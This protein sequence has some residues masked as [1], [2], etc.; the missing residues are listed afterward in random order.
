MNDKSIKVKSTSWQQ[1]LFIASNQLLN[2]VKDVVLGIGIF[3]IPLINSKI[4]NIQPINSANN[5]FDITKNILQ[6]QN[7]QVLKDISASL[8]LSCIPYSL[9]A[10]SLLRPITLNK[11]ANDCKDLMITDNGTRKGKT[12]IPIRNKISFKNPGVKELI[13]YSNGV[14][15]CDFTA[16]DKL[17][18]LSKK[19]KRYVIDVEDYKT[20]KLKIY[21]KKYAS[22]KMLF[23]KNEYL[24]RKDFELILG[25]NERGQ[26]EK[27]NF[28]KI[29]HMIIS[30]SS[31]GGK[32]TLFKSLL[33][34]SYLK[35]ARII[36]ADFKGGLDFNKGWQNL[37]HSNCEIKT[38]INSLYN[39][40]AYDIM[41]EG[42]RRIRILNEYKC[43]D[44]SEYNMK[45]D[46][47]E[48]KVE[49]LQ[50]IIIGLDEAAQVFA[51][52]K[53]KKQEETAQQVR[54]WLE[55]IS[56]LF[57]SVGIHLIISTQV[58]SSQVLTEKIRHN[59]DMRICGRANKILSN[60][61]IDNDS[62]STIP[63]S[64]RGKFITYDGIKFKSYLFYEKDV[65]L[66]LK[67]QTMNLKTDFE[68][69]IK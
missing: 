2:P 65:F 32:T 64:D 11:K 35:G 55:K 51:K 69:N 58:P 39:I 56:E 9:L 14:L 53:D 20:N 59:C 26:Q 24:S 23:W 38:N 46:N 15:A 50:R 18:R 33:M 21:Y 31:G 60:I 57:R 36:I 68:S 42:E 48:I 28:N 66:E 13:C 6:L 62:A 45:I 4:A 67:K 17:Q 52:S 44:I 54:E 3:S 61:V 19:W 16:S 40:L 1:D 12:I 47:N 41:V 5:I 43:K 37:N 22:D 25:E 34:Q 63:K 30:S 27:F 29:P 10:V 8:L 7:I 49:K